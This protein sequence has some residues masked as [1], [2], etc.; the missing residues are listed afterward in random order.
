[1][2]RT[3]A[4][5]DYYHWLIDPKNRYLT[6]MDWYKK[7]DVQIDPDERTKRLMK[8]VNYT[9]HTIA[10]D[11]YTWVSTK[12]SEIVNLLNSGIAAL[13]Q[14]IVNRLASIN[15]TINNVKEGLAKV[16][17]YISSLINN[18]VSSI[19]NV[20][21]QFAD[22]IAS[23]YNAVKQSIDNLLATMATAMFAL[24]DS[25]VDGIKWLATGIKNALK[26]VVEWVTSQLSKFIESAAGWIN[27]LGEWIMQATANIMSNALLLF[28][29]MSAR[30]VS[31]IEITAIHIKNVYDKISVTIS[32]IIAGIK[33]GFEV[34]I[35]S[36]VEFI[37]SLWE[38][39]IKLI[40]TL[41]DVSVESLQAVFTNIFRAQSGALDSLA[42]EV[43][44]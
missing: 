41:F 38:K 40:D 2:T 17:G 32:S 9:G 28:E 31:A 44:K 33:E 12:L 25:V 30:I 6:F 1:M 42:S 23:V 14:W 18:I 27:S 26:T 8:A 34:G 16:T 10:E 19:W 3:E 21:V 4:N 35:Q 29:I 13:R 37:K 20:I 39:V 24:A 22:W 11:I 43:I 15:T 7:F 36:L 5:Q